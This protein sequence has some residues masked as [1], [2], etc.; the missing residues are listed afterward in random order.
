[1]FYN[2]DYREGKIY[3]AYLDL[4]KKANFLNLNILS[5]E[6]FK[7]RVEETRLSTYM[8]FEESLIF[9]TDCFLYDLD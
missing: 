2:T 5:L 1:M 8:D 6:E 7:K 3:T 4:I 9:V